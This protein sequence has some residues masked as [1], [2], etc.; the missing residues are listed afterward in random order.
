MTGHKTRRW[1]RKPATYYT[2]FFLFIFSSLTYDHWSTI[3]YPEY[4]TYTPENWSNSHTYKRLKIA[5]D[6]LSKTDLS[7][8]KRD[9]IISI[10]G[11]PD[12][13]YP[14]QI[15]YFLSHTTAD[16]MAL[17]VT[18]DDNE[19]VMDAYIHQT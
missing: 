1:Y 19:N 7:G 16:Y 14:T 13:S 5:R 4:A 6:F 9:E 17:T 10:L 11:K 3:F 2:A 8:L 12:L 18:F 15:R